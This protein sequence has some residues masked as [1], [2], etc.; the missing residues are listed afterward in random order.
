MTRP[1]AVAVAHGS[2]RGGGGRR[3]AEI[4]LQDYDGRRTEVVAVDEDGKIEVRF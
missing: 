1:N 2:T 4:L 3:T